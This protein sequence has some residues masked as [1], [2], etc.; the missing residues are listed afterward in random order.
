VYVCENFY[1][2]SKRVMEPL[3]PLRG[4]KKFSFSDY[5]TP[6]EIYFLRKPV[7][8]QKIDWS[9]EL[10]NYQPSFSSSAVHHHQ[11]PTLGQQLQHPP[12]HVGRNV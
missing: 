4:L 6:D 12:R 7:V 11:M 2:E 5:T 10:T 1:D 3:A 8:V 9:A